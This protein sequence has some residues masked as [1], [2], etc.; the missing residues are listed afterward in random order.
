[1]REITH[2]DMHAAAC[3][4]LTCPCGDWP[5]VMAGLLADAHSADC[6]RKHSGRVH[7]RLGN[8]TLM[9]V[10]L[11]RAPDAAASCARP[12]AP[13]Y[14]QALACVLSA[15]ALWRTARQG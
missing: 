7:P 11:A 4:L 3:V 8:G 12:S 5:R 9:A 2:G 10:A 13:R 14:Q 15:L 1:M 6:Y